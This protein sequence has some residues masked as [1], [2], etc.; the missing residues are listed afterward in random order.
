M[1]RHSR[2]L[3]IGDWTAVMRQTKLLLKQAY[4]GSLMGY[5]QGPV[6]FFSCLLSRAIRCV[7]TKI[8]PPVRLVVECS[9]TPTLLVTFPWNVLW[10]QRTV[11]NVRCVINTPMKESQPLWAGLPCRSDTQTPIFAPL[12]LIPSSSGRRRVEGH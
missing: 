1:L 5:N 8:G 10:A 3:F 12:S 4:L 2:Q 9:E 6:F 11:P 7:Q